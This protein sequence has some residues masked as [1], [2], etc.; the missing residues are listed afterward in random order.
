MT[1]L[2]IW[3]VSARNVDTLGVEQKKYETMRLE[4][5]MPKIPIIA[6]LDGKAFH[7]FTKGLNRPFDI[8]LQQCMQN[9][10]L[11]LA[12]KFNVDL[13]YTQSDEISLVWYNTHQEK[14][15]F[16]GRSDKY[17]SLLAATASTAFY[18]EVVQLLPAKVKET[19]VFDCRVFQVPNAQTVFE[20]IVWRWM[21]AR[22]NSVS[23]LASSH[24]TDKE[25]HG[26]ST[27]QRKE[28]LNDI[29]VYWDN[30]SDAC[31]TGTF[32]KRTE[33]LKEVTGA[34]K[35]LIKDPI[36]CDGKIYV[37]RKKFDLVI[38]PSLYCI[39]LINTTLTSEEISDDL[40]NKVD[41]IETIFS[42]NILSNV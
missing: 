10:M 17:T 40:Q 32:C 29:S 5:M 41:L 20:N 36:L 42:E 25:L 38:P 8:N 37:K 14:M 3:P 2:L 4:R 33:Y 15:L 39:N 1:T 6:R 30:L 22:K 13:A 16:D 21:D 27:K 23:M 18:K 31:K 11:V 7:T 19:P 26:K 28:M 24:F 12:E 35:E 9:T 34:S